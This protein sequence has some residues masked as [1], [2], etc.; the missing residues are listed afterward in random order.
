MT[1][2]QVDAS[3]GQ[4]EFPIDWFFKITVALASDDAHVRFVGFEGM[5][6]HVRKIDW[7]SAPID[8]GTSI[9]DPVMARTI[10]ALAWRERKLHKQKGDPTLYGI[11]YFSIAY[12]VFWNGEFKGVI[13]VITPVSFMKEL[14]AGVAG[15][16]D[17]LGVLDTLSHDL[18]EAG[19]D[20][21]QNFDAIYTAVSQ[22]NVN[23]NALVE[24]NNLVSEVAAQTN[25]LGLNAALEA[26]R[27]GEL[28]RGFGVVADEIRRL[29]MMVKESVSQV[30][31]KVREI[32]EEIDHIQLTIQ[33]SM[34]ASEEQ[35]AQLEELSATVAHVHETTESLRSLG[36]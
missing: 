22:L 4:G 3:D 14:H 31:G 5:V 16:T 29:S 21:T 13:S 7:L 34:A 28:G 20:F 26:A 33:D 19:S 2:F 27:A 6:T 24:I 1:Y 30:H 12:P 11:P 9:D 15:L 32:T 25:L 36:S 17:Q 18:A 8:V 23:A 10:T 35:T